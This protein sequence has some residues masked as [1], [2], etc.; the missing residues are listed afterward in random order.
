MF[1]TD[2]LKGIKVKRCSN[3]H[4]FYKEGR[5][6]TKY[7]SYS[8]QNKAKT[9]KYRLSKKIREMSESGMSPEEIAIKTKSDLDT[10]IKIIQG[11]KDN[12]N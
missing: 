2:S 10:V 11:S 1:V 7:C 6:D 5:P 4:R 12:E 9:K 8:C 3:C